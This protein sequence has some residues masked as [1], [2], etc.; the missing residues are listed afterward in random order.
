MDLAEKI[1]SWDD[2]NFIITAGIGQATGD[3][4]NVKD[5]GLVAQHSYGVIGGK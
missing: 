2:R 3:C 5:M 1:C 4:E